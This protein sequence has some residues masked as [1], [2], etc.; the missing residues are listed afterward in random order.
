MSPNRV[1]IRNVASYRS[2][3]QVPVEAPGIGTVYGDI[4]WGGNWF[5]L[6]GNHGQ[7]LRARPRW[8]N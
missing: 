7:A 8:K 1:T 3:A 4:A 2:A 6:V 5:F